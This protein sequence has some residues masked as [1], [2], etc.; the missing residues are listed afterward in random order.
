[1]YDSIRCSIQWVYRNFCVNLI[2]LTYFDGNFLTKVNTCLCK[3][4]I[5]FD[6]GAFW[7]ALEF[8]I[9]EN[10]ILNIEKYHWIRNLF[11]LVVK[12]RNKQV[13]KVSILIVIERRKETVSMLVKS[14]WKHTK[15]TH[16]H[17]FTF[18]YD[19]KTRT[20]LEWTSDSF[21]LLYIVFGFLIPIYFSTWLDL[22]FSAARL[23]TS[24]IY[25]QPSIHPF[26][27]HH[28]NGPFSLPILKRKRRRKG[29]DT[30]IQ[31]A[32]VCV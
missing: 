25:I 16:I 7:K 12:N 28:L 8:G 5:E 26:I 22:L 4:W 23:Y 6:F 10:L 29:I 31:C 24:H 17:I 18:S 14:L 2:N 15:H 32:R 27:P 11:C 21:R 1:M 20:N 9:L 30:Y 19:P 3:S 13:M